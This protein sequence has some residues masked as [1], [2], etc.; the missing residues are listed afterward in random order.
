MNREEKDDDSTPAQSALSIALRAI[1]IAV[2]VVSL[3]SLRVPRAVATPQ[4]PSLKPESQVK[5][6]ANLYDAA[7]REI[8][9]ISTM[10]L[11]TADEFNRIKVILERQ[12]PNLRFNRS[13]LISLVLS[14]TTFINAAKARA[15]TKESAEEFARELATDS[16][17][18]HLQGERAL[19]LGTRLIK[20]SRQT[21]RCYSGVNDRYRGGCFQGSCAPCVSKIFT[22]HAGTRSEEFYQRHNHSNR[23]GFSANVAVMLV[24]P[25]LVAALAY[26][27]TAVVGGVFTA[28]IVTGAVTLLARV[29]AN[30]SSEPGRDRVAECQAG[31]DGQYHRCV[32]TQPLIAL[33]GR[34]PGGVA[35][36]ICGLPCSGVNQVGV[37]GYS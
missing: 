16:R 2:V 7:I 4:R 26:T 37:H 9:R 15:S 21:F 14:D 3:L 11:T 5:S 35:H 31:V 6:E 12:V 10:K 22:K 8:G 13:K 17:S 36:K 27:A 29:I 34:L 30:A 23:R 32:E 18:V 28:A 20:A 25:F 19:P 33:M 24:S 1:T